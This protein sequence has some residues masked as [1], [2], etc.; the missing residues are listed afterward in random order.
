M[1]RPITPGIGLE[2][3]GPGPRPGLG[4]P[5]PIL[6]TGPKHTKR[7]KSNNAPSTS[8][9]MNSEIPTQTTHYGVVQ[10][11]KTT[12]SPGTGSS[13]KLDKHN[14]QLVHTILISS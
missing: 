6:S 10:V 13:I 2:A 14:S 5:I 9:V 7:N 8:C 11:C 4:R 1:G 3:M 12:S